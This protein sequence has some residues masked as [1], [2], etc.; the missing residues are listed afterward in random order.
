MIEILV[1]DGFD[2]ARCVLGPERSGYHNQAVVVQD[3]SIKSM[4]VLLVSGCVIG[5]TNDEVESE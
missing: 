1:H 3:H 2:Y 5:Y 4:D